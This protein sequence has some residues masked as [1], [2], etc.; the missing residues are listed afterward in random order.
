MG[1]TSLVTY[2]IGWEFSQLVTSETD[3]VHISVAKDTNEKQKISGQMHK[4][5]P[6]DTIREVVFV[7]RGPLAM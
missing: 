7:K 4:R 3:N 5:N 2:I 1:R 6:T